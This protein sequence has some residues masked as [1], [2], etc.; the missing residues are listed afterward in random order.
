MIKNVICDEVSGMTWGDKYPQDIIWFPQGTYIINQFNIQQNTNSYNI[1]I[2]GMDKMC[3]LNGSIGGM[4]TAS[5]DFG[6]EEIYNPETQ[7]M[8]YNN[9]PIERIIKEAVHTYALEPYH[10]IIINDL[11]EAAVELLEYR[12]DSK[13]PMYLFA[14]AINSDN[15][16]LISGNFSNYT[17]NGNM[18]CFRKN[19]GPTELIM[20][21]DL[22]DSELDP[23]VNV[24]WSETYEPTFFGIPSATG[25]WTIAR[26]N[27]GEPVGYRLTDLTYA[28]E[29]ISKVGESLTSILDKIVAMLGEYEYFYDLDGRF[30]FQ[31][32]KTY[33]Q[34]TWNNI[35]KAGNEI[36]ADNAA[37]SSSY[38]YQFEDGNLITSF[39]NSP[40]LTNLRNDYSVW[41][42][43]T[44]VS[45]VKIPIHYRY[46]IDIKPKKYTSIKITE[47]E[48]LALIDVYGYPYTPSSEDLTP[49][50]ILK[51]KQ[52]KYAQ[53]NVLYSDSEYDWRE[54]IYRM[55]QD[56]FK[57]GQLEYYTDKL[58]AANPSLNTTGSTGYEQYYIDLLGQW[59]ELYNPEP[60]E[61]DKDNFNSATDENPYWTK[62][63][64]T[65][66]ELLNFWFDF[67]D[68]N[69]ELG[70]F[71]VQAVGDRVKAINDNNVTAIYFKEVPDLI[72]TTPKEWSK[73]VNVT[74]Y[75]PVFM[76]NSMESLLKISSQG[77]SAQDAIDELI[78]Q[79]SY[80][81]ESVTVQAVPVYSLQPNTRI[82]IRDHKSNI[83]GEYL[84]S[85]ISLPLAYN[86]TMSITATKAP[87]R[88]R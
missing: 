26:V 49:D 86:G 52:Q 1:S 28:G 82:I 41:G 27:Y 68:A 25:Y 54:I 60:S 59:R 19:E 47:D 63:L 43:R 36:Y 50:E 14:K 32:K 62:Q 46:A 88:I 80:C 83:E 7:T 76:N 70:Q 33:I 56:D 55:A 77:K 72:F 74:G 69:S 24:N 73:R 87:Q 51:E 13:T 81:I 31:R 39:S 42:Q 61:E 8:D 2:S 57:Y 4:L 5:I 23:R 9:I 30:V 12:G 10:N 67:L 44:S 21:K 35:V 29:L 20:L 17:L 38:I 45:G 6:V 75:T 3:L 15:Q 34:S 11:D 78:Y 64:L 22:L 66:P 40:N 18:Q 79:H 48:S 58:I 65:S 53:N 71:S 16:R 85:K 37:Y 84:V